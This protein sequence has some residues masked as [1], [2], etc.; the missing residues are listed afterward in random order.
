MHNIKIPAKNEK[1]TMRVRGAGSH[2]L[3]HSHVP[4]LFSQ[5]FQ[6]SVCRNA[7]P[8]SSHP[9]ET[10]HLML[11]RTPA[12]H[13]LDLEESLE[14]TFTQRP[15]EPRDSGYTEPLVLLHCSSRSYSYACS[16]RVGVG[17]PG[18]STRYPEE[19]MQV[20]LKLVFAL[21]GPISL[22]GS[23][24]SP[25]CQSRCSRDPPEGEL[26]FC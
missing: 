1:Y 23:I 26:V 15:L 12:P 5:G 19:R 22:N 9:T 16:G 24:P 21:T 17:T 13:H 18:G 11:S 8:L 4:V 10:C 14:V 7:L 2:R 20:S 3:G 25:P 6:G